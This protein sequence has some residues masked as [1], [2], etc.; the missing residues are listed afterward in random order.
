MLAV[1]ILPIGFMGYGLSVFVFLYSQV[2]FIYLFI[3][4]THNTT[5]QLSTLFKI[6]CNV[7]MGYRKS[8]DNACLFFVLS[9]TL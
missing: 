8:V 1:D 3:G 4:E 5:G 7:C 9:F 2:K 6:T